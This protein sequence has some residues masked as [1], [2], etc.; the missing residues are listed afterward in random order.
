M[1]ERELVV[2][3]GRDADVIVASRAPL[4]TSPDA[5]FLEESWSPQ[6][7]SS[8]GDGGRAREEDGARVGFPGSAAPTLG[9]VNASE[10]T[11]SSIE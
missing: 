5:N 8:P 4:T 11:W 9:T 6:R 10:P 2:G 3:A 7:V 1:A